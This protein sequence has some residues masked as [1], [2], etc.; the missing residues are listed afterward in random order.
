MMRRVMD[1]NK[2]VGLVG[3]ND[4]DGKVISVGVAAC[5]VEAGY[6]RIPRAS[7]EIAEARR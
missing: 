1:L 6:A 7:F 3:G 4:G 5:G 2:A